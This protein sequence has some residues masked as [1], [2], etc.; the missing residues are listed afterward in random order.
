[1]TTLGGPVGSS[2]TNTNLQ[3]TVLGGIPK[4]TSEAKKIKKQSNEDIPELV[5]CVGSENRKDILEPYIKMVDFSF[6][7]FKKIL[8]MNIF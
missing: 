7:F 4:K 2:P 5:S 3:G 8:L 1:M 6:F